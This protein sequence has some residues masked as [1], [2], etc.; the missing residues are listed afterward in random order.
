M[1]IQN[2][3]DKLNNELEK[4][5]KLRNEQIDTNSFFTNNVHFN[6]DILPEDLLNQ[7][8]SNN[9]ETNSINISNTNSVISYENTIEPDNETKSL[10]VKKEN[11]LFVVQNIFKK[12]IKF[13]LKSFLISIS[14]SFLNLF[15]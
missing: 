5:N 11:S 8:N 2:L 10:V 14:L 6:D 1:D 3:I 9:T 15:I 7:E 4:I 13:S 12:S